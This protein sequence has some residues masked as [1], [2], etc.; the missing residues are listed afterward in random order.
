M[1]CDT[2][3]TDPLTG[4]GSRENGT[5]PENRPGQGLTSRGMS[6]EHTG[7]PFG[8]PGTTLKEAAKGRKNSAA[9]ARVIDP[10]RDASDVVGVPVSGS[11]DLVR[12]HPCGYERGVV[13]Q[14]S[15][16]SRSV[17]LVAT[18]VTAMLSWSF[19]A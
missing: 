9:E 3:R 14:A 15:A 17:A 2:A 10:A 8:P 16:G 5:R 1:N 12:T 6:G 19:C 13:V 11:T 4:G 18:S 7:L